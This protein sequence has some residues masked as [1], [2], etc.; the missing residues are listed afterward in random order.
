M[1]EATVSRSGRRRA[2]TILVPLL[3]ALIF[4][5]GA[6]A[7]RP[8]E[9]V[10]AD[11]R[12]AVARGEFARAEAMLDEALRRAG[13][14]DDEVVWALRIERLTPL[15]KRADYATAAAVLAQ[16]LPARL[17]GSEPAARRLMAKAMLSWI[18]GREAE[19]RA[20]L[21]A[22]SAMVPKLPPAT[23]VD[24]L[25]LRGN[26]LKDERAGQEALRLARASRDKSAIAKAQAGLV[27]TYGQVNKIAEAVALGETLIGQLEQL[28]L[29]ALLTSHT[30][31]LGWL[32]MELGDY[33]RARE[34]FA[35]AEAECVRMN[36]RYQRPIWLTNIGNAHRARGD[37]VQAERVYRQVLALPSA[38]EHRSTSHA[39]ANL[40]HVLLE[41]GRIAEARAL[42][43]QALDYD[44]T[45]RPEDV[46]KARVVA[47][48][49]DLATGN[50][51]N[52]QKSF[53]TIIGS[54]SNPFTKIDAQMVLAQSYVATKQNALAE[55]AFARAVELVRAMRTSVG[56]PQLR[57]ALFNTASE[58]F[59]SYVDY[60][61]GAGRHEEA[62]R[63]TETSRAQTL[64]EGVA[65]V[66]KAKLD[67]RKI[68]ARHQATILCYWLGRR[69]SYVWIVTP[70]DMNLAR[71][72]R[73]E[74]DI[75][76]QVEQYRARLVTAAGVIERS[77]PNGQALFNLLVA[78]AAQRL[79]RGARVIVVPDGK[80][81]TLN[82]ETLVVPGSAPRYWINDVIVSNASSLQLLG[83]PSAPVAPRA[84][85][86]LVGNPPQ[87]DDAFPMLP[88]A[89]DEIA[90]VAA[91]FPGYATVLDGAAATPGRYTAAR[92][93]TFD[94]IHF[95]AH[96]VASR[97][98]PL[99]SAVILGVDTDRNYR[100]LA[101][102]IARRRLAARLVTIS[103]CHGA[104]EATY[105]GEGL[106]GLAW[107]FLHAGAQQVVAAL[108]A[109]TDTA[110]PKLMDRMYAGIREGKDP[111]VALREAKLAL[112]ASGTSHKHAKFWAP[113]VIY[114]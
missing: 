39:L 2:K 83:R 8:L 1:A 64:A 75:D 56:D 88:Y 70:N 72:G 40:G 10:L 79:A 112:L 69:N 77:A 59:D 101:R 25:L 28:G 86:L 87:A 60:L 55:A 63:V 99:D 96:G 36:D 31:N 38:G 104:G 107:A 20:H 17:E 95:V 98:R 106:V 32:F 30:G 45:L 48:R 103:S 58:L 65:A 80:L 14:R 46:F 97:T 67:A 54:T 89:G 3:L 109:V 105:A 62:L 4:G 81:H 66:P 35:F 26:L 76:R 68:A 13:N 53:P 102:D 61:V 78:P 29:R 85:M 71:L 93:Q 37:W 51:R 100:L 108:W 50:Y 11:A 19:A 92:P 27:F 41:Q 9:K 49:I 42:V 7:P 12:V 23:A 6:A 84:T 34:L 5:A 18:H 73:S 52:V 21:A 15:I 74:S 94:Y 16:P 110:A 91:R 57:V 111:A 114:Q 90:R 44:Q 33:E 22:A 113:F 82:F 47:G 43:Q 24:V